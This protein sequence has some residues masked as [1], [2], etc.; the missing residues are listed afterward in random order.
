MDIYIG[1]KK[2]TLK[3][4]IERIHSITYGKKVLLED[5]LLTKLIQGGDKNAIKPID[6]PAKADFVDDDVRKFF[7][8]LKSIDEPLNQQKLGSMTYQK[9]VELIQIGLIL[10][11][12]EL[13][14]HGVDGLFGP[15]TAEAVRKYKTD[16]NILSESTSPYDGGGNVKIDR[17]V[18]ANLNTILQSKIDAIASEYGKSFT[19]VSG[20]RDPGYNAK[21][22]G[23]GKSEHMNHN[24]VDIHLDDKTK[25]DTLRFV[26]ISSK[27][28]I[29]GIGVYNPGVIHIDVGSRRAWGHT[30]K[31]ASVPSWAESTIQAHE[32]N[33]IDTGYVSNYDSS[34]DDSSS[35]QL[36]I[37]TVTPEMVQSMVSKLET[38]GVTKEQLSQLIDK[39]TTGG[40]DVFTDL[41]LTTEEGYKMYSDISDIFIKSRKPNLLNIT[42]DMMASSAKRTFEKRNKY[43]PPELALGQLAAEGGIGNPDANTLPIKTKNPFN[44]GNTD[45]GGKVDH[46]S[47][48]SGIDAYYDLIARDYIGKGRTAQDLINNFVNHE[49]SRYAGAPNYEKVVGSIARQVNKIA[50]NLGAN[51]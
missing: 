33:K 5:N 18:D 43:I 35:N 3:E 46:S 44:V 28:G 42:G 11:G 1:M 26:E 45:D 20:Y 16:N 37:E 30:H 12:Y 51:S 29:G 41:D 50:K 2:R 9:N 13:P 24:A 22:G 4:E 47:V 34:A 40:S 27:N 8:D 19:I 14:R 6:D 21:I 32:A 36:T 48:Q 31:R 25:E 15:E 17:D 39:V 38:K 49:N 10:L 23:A 7:T